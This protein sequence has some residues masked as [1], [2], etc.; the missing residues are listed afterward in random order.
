MAYLLY[1]KHEIKNV[2]NAKM[3]HLINKKF[4]ELWHEMASKPNHNKGKKQYGESEVV[5]FIKK[6]NL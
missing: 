5:S 3:I 2:H 4:R 6:I 1:E